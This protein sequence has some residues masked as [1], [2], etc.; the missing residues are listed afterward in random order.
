MNIG[1]TNIQRAPLEDLK[2]VPIKAPI[3]AKAGV[4]GEV[5]QEAVT[6]AEVVK[7]EGKHRGG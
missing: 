6:K 4:R 3:K 7:V 1:K 2:I 5:R